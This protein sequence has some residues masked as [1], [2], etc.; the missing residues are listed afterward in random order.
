MYVDKKK[1]F[2]TT[3]TEL[4]VNFDTKLH[5]LKCFEHVSD[6]ALL[7]IGSENQPVI[8]IHVHFL[9]NRNFD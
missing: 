4:E 7:E 2:I 6:D 1:T 5:R 9:E 3:L 8:I